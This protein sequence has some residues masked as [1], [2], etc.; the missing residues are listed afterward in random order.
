MILALEGAV[1]GREMVM[2]PIRNTITLNLLRGMA[3]ASRHP[4]AVSPYLTGNTR[5]GLIPEPGMWAAV[6]G[7]GL[8]MVICTA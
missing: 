2:P 5:T 3:S 6:A 8:A 7:S 1:F 4:L